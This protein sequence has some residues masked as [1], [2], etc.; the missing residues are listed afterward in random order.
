ME[1]LDKI[2]SSLN[3]LSYGLYI[4][5]SSS[6]GKKNGQLVN[7]VFQLTPNPPRI[8]ICLNKENLTHE[9]I[10]KSGFFSVSILEEETPLPFIGLFGFK[11][12]R[13]IDK[14]EKTSHKMEG[15]CPIVTENTLSYLN[16]KVVSKMDADSHTLFMGQVI[17]GEVLKEGNRLT[18]DFYQKNKKGRTHKNATTFNK[19]TEANK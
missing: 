4:V 1:N 17:N 18:Y 2:F 7:T 6:D 19:I 10:N 14:F 5:A 16:V 3:K 8:A 15:D 12:G 11:S 13:D 9:I